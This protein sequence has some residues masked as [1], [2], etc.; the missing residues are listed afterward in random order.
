MSAIYEE[1]KQ[2][3]PEILSLTQV[4]YKAK[5]K[6]RSA[7]FSK[8]PDISIDYAIMEKSSRLA[9]ICSSVN[10]D[11]VG[12]Y[13]ALSRIQPSDENKNFSE[14]ASTVLSLDASDNIVLA[15]ST[16]SLLGINNCVIV[17]KNGVILVAARNSLEKVKLLRELAP[18]NKK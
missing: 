4:V 5:E 10:W 16:V 12:S 18:D 8:M 2:H 11:D 7:I 15:D 14:Q 13:E 3:Q 9:V 6:K 17:E 1:F